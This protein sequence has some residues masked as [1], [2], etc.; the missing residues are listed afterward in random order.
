MPAGGSHIVH[1]CL[2]CMHLSQRS[3]RLLQLQ[4]APLKL[5]GCCRM[6]HQGTGSSQR[7]RSDRLPL[8][9]RGPTR[10]RPLQTASSSPWLHLTVCSQLSTS[11]FK[12]SQEYYIMALSQPRQV[13]AVGDSEASSVEDD[14]EKDAVVHSPAARMYHK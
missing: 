6:K 8:E 13:Q 5:I 10:S 2:L 7:V 11:S 4:C 14:A 12:F 3:P 1:Q 9:L